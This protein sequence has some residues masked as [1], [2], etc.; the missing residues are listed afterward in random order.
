MKISEFVKNKRGNKT[1]LD[2]SKE[3]GISNTQL[4][5]IENGFWDKPSPTQINNLCKIFDLTSDELDVFKIPGDIIYKAFY[6]S[7]VEN[8]R[9]IRTCISNFY[10]NAKLNNKKFKDLY[11]EPEFDDVKGLDLKFP[12]EGVDAVCISKNKKSEFIPFYFTEYK[13]TYEKDNLKDYDRIIRKYYSNFICTLSRILLNGKIKKA[14]IITNSKISYDLL[15]N[16]FKEIPNVSP[17]KEIILAYCSIK[18]KGC[19]YYYK[20]I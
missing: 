15:D 18:N 19:E 16:W 10:N 4:A 8:M 9:I 7:Y 2:Y 5:R 1:V 11:K 20:T 14:I 3:L 6:H 13:R 12:K 17:N